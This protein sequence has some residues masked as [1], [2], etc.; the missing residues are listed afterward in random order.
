MR[1]VRVCVARGQR[2]EQVG[3]GRDP[4]PVLLYRSVSLTKSK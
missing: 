4:T 2:D 1:A 3:R